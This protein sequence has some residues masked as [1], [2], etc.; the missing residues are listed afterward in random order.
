MLQIISFV[1]IL[2]LLFSGAITPSDYPPHENAAAERKADMALRMA[3]SDAIGHDN[4]AYHINNHNATNPDHGYDVQFGSDNV[5]I[6]NNGDT[7]SVELTGYGYGDSLITPVEPSIEQSAN[8][9]TYHRD[10]LDEWYINGQI[11]LQQGFTLY[12]PP[13]ASGNGELTLLMTLSG[14]MQ[15]A[16]KS[17][18]L[19]LRGENRTNLTYGGLYAF[20]ADGQT[21]SARFELDGNELAIVADDSA[22]TYPVTIDPWVQT[23]KFLPDDGDV[24]DYFGFA[25]ALDGDTAVVGAYQ[26]ED[27]GT[28]S[29]SAYVF[30]RSG[31][32]WTQQAKLLPEDGSFLDKFGHSVA[33]SGDTLLVGAYNDAVNGN[34]SGSAYVFVRSGTTWSQQAKLVPLDGSSDDYFDYYSIALDG[35]TALIPAYRDSVNG[36]NSGSAYVFTRSGTTWSQQTKLIPDDGAER[37]RFGLSVALE[38]D[39]AVI[40][41]YLDDNAQP[42]SGSAYVFVRDGSSWS[43]QA[44][45][46]PDDAYMGDWFGSD[47][48]LSGDTVLVGAPGDDDNGGS[49]GSAYVFTRSGT[50]WSQQAKLLPDDGDT[51]DYFGTSVAISGDTALAGSVLDGDNGMFSGSAYVF[52]RNGATW[53]QYDKLLPND[54]VAEARFGISVALD[55]GNVLVGAYQ[56]DDNGPGSGSVYAFFN[57]VSLSVSAT[58]NSENLSVSITSGDG[59]FDITASAGIN[60]PVLSVSTGITTINGPEKWDDLTV[61]E[62]SGDAESINLGQFK[63]RTDERPIP[64]TPA[65]RTHTTDTTPTFSWTSITDANNYRVFLFDDKVAA[66]RTIDIRQ[67]SGG[68]TFLTVSTPLPTKRLFWRVRGRQNRVWSLWSVRSTLFVDP[69]TFSR[70]PATG[71]EPTTELSLSPPNQRTAPAPAIVP[72]QATSPYPPNSR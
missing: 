33:V 27:N 22:A 51:I 18:T 42:D 4:S 67:N 39:I 2:Y 9:I 16:L 23:Y 1:F 13:A 3:Y 45:L 14:T 24:D 15:A 6:L 61:T 71:P 43:Q 17:D 44:K 69:Q 57:V 35:D 41:A 60:T 29:G 54:G 72:P 21:L 59:P 47:V 56:D 66:N 52:T 10:T 68:P 12:E 20:D 25:V 30:I 46:L 8:R 11:G 32:T 63:C 36:F 5:S 64:L 31:A 28:D 40:G 7:W 50:T 49:S 19:H 53:N 55:S 62:T 37:D 34:V 70:A 38:D 48:A 26:D 58:C 65:H